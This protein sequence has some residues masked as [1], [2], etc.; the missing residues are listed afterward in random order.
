MKTRNRR[1]KLYSLPK[2]RR[3]E[4]LNRNEGGEIFNASLLRLKC[5]E[6]IFCHSFHAFV[7][8]NQ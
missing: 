4:N 1:V 8:I 6:H 7:M 3:N 5:L 2:A